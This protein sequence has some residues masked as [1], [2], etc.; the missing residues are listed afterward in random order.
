MLQN[1][2]NEWNG[3]KVPSRGGITGQ[4]V[5]LSQAWA[6]VNGVTGS[7]V[8]P[9]E[10]ARQMVGTRPDFF[11][12]EANRVGDVNQK[13]IAGDIVVFDGSYGGGAG[14]TG[15]VVASDGYTMQVFQQNDPTGKGAYTKTYGFGGCSGWL[16]L[17]QTNLGGS[18]AT[19]VTKETLRIIHSE[20]EGWPLNEVHAGK[21]D[22]QFWASWG[23]K[24]LEEC[25]WEKWNK[26]GAYR[27]E[28]EAALDYWRNKKKGVEDQVKSQ[29]EQI[30]KQAAEIASLKA[31]IVELGKQPVVTEDSILIDETVKQAKK[32]WQRINISWGKKQ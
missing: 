21:F 31:Q 5:S 32:W 27:N 4:C 18:M 15:V 7:P 16:R 20:M 30:T 29:Q 9:V 28:R 19:K 8:F 1:F 3:K 17:K 12:W 25:I 10:V 11:T 6:E 2:I 24:D 26:N 23:G 22:A 13:P 14:H